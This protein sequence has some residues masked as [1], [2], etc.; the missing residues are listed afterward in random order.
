MLSQNQALSTSGYGLKRIPPVMVKKQIKK[1]TKTALIK[2]LKGVKLLTLDVDGVQTDGGLYYTEDG[3]QLRKFHVH[4][5]VGIKQAMALGVTVAIVTASRTPS[6]KHRGRILGVQHV[7]VGVEDKLSVVTGI[8]E[9]LGI[10]ISEVAHIGDDL[11]DLPLLQSVGLA[12]TVAN[13][14]PEV[15]EAVAYITVKEGG[16]GAVREISDLLIKAK[17]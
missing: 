5:G 17:S 11:N 10:D 4:D 1:L 16:S 7:L 9:A 12:L 3:K 15:L 13:A 14:V 6:I 8:C 2:R